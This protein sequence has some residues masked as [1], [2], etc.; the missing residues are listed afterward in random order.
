MSVLST[1]YILFKADSSAAKKDTTALNKTL[2]DTKVVADKATA[3]FKGLAGTLASLV[4]V[5]AIIAGIKQSINFADKL[6]ELSKA[7]DVNIEDLSAWGDAV[8]M[9]GGSAQSFQDSVRTITASLADFATKG[10]SRAAPFFKELGI[11]MTDAQGRARSFVDVLPEIATA[12]EKISK[13][14]SFGIGT[15]MGLD[16]GTIMLLQQGRIAVEDVV[17][18]QKELGVVTKEDA[19]IA[20]K[21]N[22]QVDIS[23]HVFRSM[24]TS[25]NSYV[26]PPLT[27]F[28]EKLEELQK[29]FRKHPDIIK[30]AII[31]ISVALTRTLIPAIAATVRAFG[32]WMKIIAI[33]GAVGY[34]VGLLWE[35][36]K[37]FQ[38]GGDSLIGAMLKRWPGLLPIFK[39]LGWLI[40]SIV[41]SL[42]LLGEGAKWF[43]DRLMWA[44]D[45]L[46]G[47]LG[48]VA[49]AIQAAYDAI[50]G[51]S[52]SKEINVNANVNYKGLED[53]SK[54]VN[55]A[56]NSPIASQSI[57][58]L[59]S[60][61]SK[62]MTQSNSVQIG[63]VVVNT[64]ATD[65]NGISRDIGSSLEAQIAQVNGNFSNGVAA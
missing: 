39:A 13:Q 27:K 5:G 23:M 56:G 59:L 35:D 1:L 38:A 44:A 46:L 25:I 49:D 45:V 3:A 65:A 43:F 2:S 31:G 33:I 24:F 40:K 18:R 52:D 60:P 54:Q 11:A 62:Y 26:L 6:D 55:M 16:Q 10:T 42:S 8:Q 17:R 63:E 57:S 30:G 9:S 4:S 53:M 14:E 32:P 15:K 51:G 7:L 20:A 21:F 41:D 28:M 19:E 22:D 12:F 50:F 48:K 36:F 47:T 37:V 29:W 61:S 34:A 64:Q 58:S